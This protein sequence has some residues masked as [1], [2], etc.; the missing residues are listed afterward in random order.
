[1]SL[2]LPSP[3]FSG[4][5]DSQCEKNCAEMASRARA[6]RKRRADHAER[7]GRDFGIHSKPGPFQR[8]VTEVAGAYCFKCDKTGHL[9]GEC[10]QADQQV[11]PQ[12]AWVE[13]T[14]M[15]ELSVFR[16]T[17]L[18]ANQGID[19]ALAEA[20]PKRTQSAVSRRSGDVLVTEKATRGV[21][22][23]NETNKAA[24]P[25]SAM[26]TTRFDDNIVLDKTMHKTFN[27]RKARASENL[28]DALGRPLT[29]TKRPERPPTR[30]VFSLSDCKW[31]RGLSQVHVGRGMVLE[32]RGDVEA[33][34]APAAS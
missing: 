7:E 33:V 19:R 30:S 18:R 25:L 24:R 6:L 9:A 20:K 22:S 27:L 28:C 14:N 16:K 4:G 34:V 26:S 21:T 2:F 10:P 31:S 1:M 29:G 23:L 12:K 5:H 32:N 13:P 17:L 3:S 15:K 11:V 8:D